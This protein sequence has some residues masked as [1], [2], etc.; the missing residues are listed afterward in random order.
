MGGSASK[1]QDSKEP[2]VERVVVTEPPTAEMNEQKAAI[3]IYK[4]VD[5]VANHNRSQFWIYETRL[6][7]KDLRGLA[8]VEE[9]LTEEPFMICTECFYC[10]QNGCAWKLCGSWTSIQMSTLSCFF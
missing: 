5:R 9:V 4:E 3:T 10:A 7:S 8:I 1:P 2:V 6:M